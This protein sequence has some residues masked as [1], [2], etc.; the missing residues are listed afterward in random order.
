[1]QRPEEATQREAGG[2]GEH[3]CCDDQGRAHLSTFDAPPARAIPAR[4]PR[5]LRTC[6]TPHDGP[7]ERHR[8]TPTKC[9]SRVSPGF[10]VLTPSMRQT[11]APSTSSLNV[12]RSS[13]LATM[14]I[15][16]A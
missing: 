2:D 15:C 6:A 9:T 8:L 3:D 5:L 16:V 14:A 13:V 12:L 4:L 10:R 7:A 11:S 1:M